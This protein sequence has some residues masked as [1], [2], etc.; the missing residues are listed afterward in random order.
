MSFQIFTIEKTQYGEPVDILAPNEITLSQLVTYFILPSGIQLDVGSVFYWNLR[1]TEEKSKDD[2]TKRNLEAIPDKIP[3]GFN[4]RVKCSSLHD[5]SAKRMA[6]CRFGT[7]P[8]CFALPEDATLGRF[9][10]RVADWMSQRGQGGDWTIEGADQD[11]IDWGRIYEVIPVIR[12]API[13]IFLKQIELEILPSLSWINL[14]DQLLRKWGLTKGTLLRI[15]PADGRVDNRDDEDHS[16]TFDWEAGKQCWFDIAYDLSK[17]PGDKAKLI[18]MI[19]QYGRVDRMVVKKEAS[20]SH[21]L[22]QWTKLL[23]IPTSIRLG[24]G[25]NNNIDYFWTYR[26]VP[27]TIPCVFRTS[28]GQGNACIFDGPHQFKAEQLGRILDIRFPPLDLCQISRED[29]GPVI[30]Q[31]QGEVQRLGLRILNEHILGWNLEERILFDPDIS[32]WW[33]PYDFAAI[34]R[35]GHR[36]HS[37]IPDDVSQAIFPDLPWPERVVIRIKSQAPPQVPAAPLPAGGTPALPA[38]G[39]P[40]GWKGAALGQ[41]QPISADASGLVGYIS[42]NQGQGSPQGDLPPEPALLSL[43]GEDKKNEEIHAL[44]SWTTRKDYPLLIGISLPAQYQVGEEF[45]EVQLWEETDEDLIVEGNQAAMIY[46][47][48]NTRILGRST[49]QTLPANMPRAMNDVTVQTWKDGKNGYILFTPNAY[50]TVPVGVMEVQVMMEYHL[51]YTRIGMG[52]AYTIKMLSDEF[53]A[54][55]QEH[56]G[57]YPLQGH[58]RLTDGTVVH[59][60][61]NDRNLYWAVAADQTIQ[62]CPPKILEERGR[63]TLITNQEDQGKLLQYWAHGQ[64]ELEVGVGLPLNGRK[65]EYWMKITLQ[66]VP[67]D[68]GPTIYLREVYRL[69]KERLSSISQQLDV[70]VEDFYY[71]MRYIYNSIRIWYIPQITFNEGEYTRPFAESRVQR[72]NGSPSPTSWRLRSQRRQMIRSAKF[73]H[74]FLAQITG[75][76]D[77]MMILKFREAKLYSLHLSILEC[78]SHRAY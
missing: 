47:W 10:E 70:L 35:R 64:K 27:E 33:V 39:L 17:Y 73:P 4:L 31:F 32:T 16:Y 13:R 49:I 6:S 48:L 24:I 19:D 12:E 57:I 74:S 53:E 36:I 15:F 69:S 62:V 43:R 20:D 77:G 58:R 45:H 25:S 44:I 26:S 1:E 28:A 66:P 5:R 22:A 14:S 29:K 7:V 37:A 78:K 2:K 75:Y 59:S 30:I 40:S 61:T 68:D 11:C 42:P 38:P 46:D 55:T 9:K 67:D 18:R 34:M 72:T 56:W 50:L 41:A 52:N 23:G 21:I 60:V 63:G 76:K 3:P 51:G 71:R 8:L 65:C 54:V